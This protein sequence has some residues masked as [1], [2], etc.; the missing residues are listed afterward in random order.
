MFVL[1][2]P[3]EPSFSGWRVAEV[4]ET[5]F[6]VAAPFFWLEVAE[7]PANLHLTYYDPQTQS[8]AVHT[9]PEPSTAERRAKM[10]VTPLQARRALRA[11]GLLD[12]VEAWVA[13]QDDDAQDAWEYALQIERNNPMI[14]GAGAALGMTDAQIDALFVAAAAW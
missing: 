7:V 3:N 12:A 1:I 14:A 4:H 10:V 6:P 13:Q 2:S 9:P 8:L 5:G 11:A